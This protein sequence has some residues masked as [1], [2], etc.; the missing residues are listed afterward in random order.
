MKSF[1]LIYFKNS[2]EINLYLRQFVNTRYFV[3]ANLVHT[4]KSKLCFVEKKQ[5]MF[6]GNFTLRLRNVQ[7]IFYTGVSIYIRSAVRNLVWVMLSC[8]IQQYKHVEI[9]RI[10]VIVPRWQESVPAKV[11]ANVAYFWLCDKFNA[12]VIDPVASEKW[13]SVVKDRF[14]L[15]F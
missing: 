15:K 6:C 3:I 7:G 14:K 8:N 4:Y 11:K 12:T 13:K 10:A 2:T 9:S 5:I 1:F